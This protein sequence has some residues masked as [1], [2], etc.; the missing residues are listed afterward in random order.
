MRNIR[1]D[2]RGAV[3]VEFG[4]VIVPLIATILVAI[5][6]S[7]LLFSQQAMETASEKIARLVMTGQAQ[8]A[9]MTQSGFKTLVCNTLP[10]FMPCS[11]VMVDITAYSDI[12]LV[13]TQ[14]PS[15][16][17]TNG[18]VSN[19]WNYKLGGQKEIVRMRIMYLTPTI[20]G[21]LD[22]SLANQ[23]DG[24]RLLISTSVFRNE[25]S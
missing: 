15:L 17:Y 7:I 14:N 5:Q 12:S 8:G 13:D 23:P 21:P 9:N 1:G 2:S 6:T 10:S 18:Q 24:K 3:I 19:S 16:T 11:A 20:F 22:S 25:S 4:F